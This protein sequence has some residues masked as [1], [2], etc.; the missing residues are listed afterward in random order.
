M[1]RLRVS[2]KALTEDALRPRAEFHSATSAAKLAVSAEGVVLRSAL[3]VPIHN[4]LSVGGRWF[5]VSDSF[6]GV[7][8]LL[9]TRRLV[10]A[11]WVV[12]YYDASPAK[13]N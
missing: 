12:L 9:L 2:A 5:Y 3:C 10:S 11:S 1:G 13:H 8:L 4:W 7:G 6:Y